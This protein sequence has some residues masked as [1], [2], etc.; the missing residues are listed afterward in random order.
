MINFHV[1]FAFVD[2]VD[3]LVHVYGIETLTVLTL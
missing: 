3:I 1:I 2:F